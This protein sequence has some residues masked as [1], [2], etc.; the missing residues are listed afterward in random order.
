VS[1]RP[2]N[3]P[4][5]ELYNLVGHLVDKTVNHVL[6]GQK[7]AA[8]DGIPGMELKA[9]AFLR[10][11]HRRRAALRANRVGTHELNLRNETDVHLSPAYAGRLN[12][13][14]KTG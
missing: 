8:F 3:T 2:G 10:T 7:I 6:V 9:V 12:R 11:E 5:V 14:P 4:V 1:P 13:C